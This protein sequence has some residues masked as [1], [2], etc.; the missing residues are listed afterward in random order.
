MGPCLK[1]SDSF[2]HEM[3]SGPSTKEPQLSLAHMWS[4]RKLRQAGT[5]EQQ[6]DSDEVHFIFKIKL[7]TSV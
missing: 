3:L 1:D 5:S 4:S 6:L 7:K 2:S